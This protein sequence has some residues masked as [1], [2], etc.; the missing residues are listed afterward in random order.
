MWWGDD[1]TLNEAV[2][3]GNIGGDALFR[4]AE[5]LGIDIREGRDR[6]IMKVI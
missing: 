5:R 2:S 4:E 1:G 6:E 3:K